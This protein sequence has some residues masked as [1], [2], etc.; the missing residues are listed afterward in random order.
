MKQLLL[1]LV[2]ALP[3]FGQFFG[4]GS[5]RLVGSDPTG[6][7]CAAR[8]VVNYQGTLYSCQAGVFAVV[9]G[10]AGPPMD[11]NALTEQT[12]PVLANDSVATYDAAA[13]GLRKV[14]LIN[15]P[16]LVKANNLSDLAN[17]ATARTNLGLGNVTNDAQLKAASNLSDLANATTARDNLGVEIGVDVQ[18]YHAYL[19]DLAALTATNG[20]VLMFNGTTVVRVEIPDCDGTSEKLSFTQATRTFACTTDQT[21]GGGGATDYEISGT[22]TATLAIAA[23]SVDINGTYY[24]HSAATVEITAGTSTGT[25]K[26]YVDP[27]GVMT[28][29]VPTGVT[30]TCTNC[31]SA[32]SA[33]PAFPGGSIKPIANVTISYP[34]SGTSIWNTSTAQKGTYSLRAFEPST[35]LEWT[36]SSKG[37]MK[38]DSTVLTTSGDHVVAGSLDHS[39]STRTKPYRQVANA[40]ARTTPCT[41]YERVLQ[42]DTNVVYGCAADGLSWAADGGGA[43]GSMLHNY[44]FPAGSVYSSTSSYGAG[45]GAPSS[46][47]AIA[48]TTASGAIRYASMLFEDGVATR[49]A[50]LAFRLPDNWDD[51]KDVSL[52]LDWANGS[53]S[54]TG[55]F[56]SISTGCT[57]PGDAAIPSFNTSQDAT[58]T[59]ISSSNW[60][61]HTVSTLTATG[62]L[63]GDRMFILV[64]RDPNNVADDFAGNMLVLGATVKIYEDITQ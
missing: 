41:A 50:S 51:S 64:T 59:P 9:A 18:A 30:T 34:G 53:G 56:V 45:W 10:S 5:I 43:S 15:L 14:K 44:Y 54:G 48:T 38:I 21:G 12:S 62:C 40:A 22:G 61:T 20:Y 24:G 55:I 2:L 58:L 36:D 19:A 37:A 16:F 60:G 52:A 26:V 29:I 63:A 49:S 4:G 13:A 8:D 3:G 1:L 27:N 23:G 32:E 35:G 46:A 6:N 31:T 47:G 25:A 17:A 57:S 28:V 39:A 33:S 42:I 11:I 7:A